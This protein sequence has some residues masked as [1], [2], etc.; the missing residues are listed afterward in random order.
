MD[1]LLD[2]GRRNATLAELP[3]KVQKRI[4]QKTA[5]RQASAGSAAKKI[6]LSFVKATLGKNSKL[7]QELQEIETLRYKRNREPYLLTVTELARLLAKLD[8]RTA[9]LMRTFFFTSMGWEEYSVNGFDVT[10]NFIHIKGQKTD[11]RD[12]R[13]PL[14][15]PPIKTILTKDALANRVKKVMPELVPYDMRRSYAGLLEEARIPHS[16]IQKY[17]GHA[18]QDMTR[19][20]QYNPG[21]KMLVPDAELVRDFI[22]A[23]LSIQPDAEKLMSLIF[24]DLSELPAIHK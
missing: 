18:D 21:V 8:Y 20:Y 24:G 3:Q 7:Y 14:I 11:R 19:A 16:R 15:V 9:A 12:R 17:F 10:E 1:L 2:A 5:N 6:A 4:R 13:V 22:K 23:E